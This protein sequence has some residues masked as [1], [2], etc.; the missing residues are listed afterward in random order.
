MI[1]TMDRFTLDENKL[2]QK[3][4]SEKLSQRG[5][6]DTV[7][8]KQ[9][10]VFQDLIDLRLLVP[11]HG[12]EHWSDRYEVL[13]GGRIAWIPKNRKHENLIDGGND[14]DGRPFYVCRANFKE[15]TIPGKFYKPTGCCYV[16]TGG[17]E[18]CAQDYS[19]MQKLLGGNEIID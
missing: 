12:S 19:L 14:G 15:M 16:A 18:H 17:K 3:L 11:K 4:S 10:I 1:T 6:A 8:I 9:F 5:K 13:C 2:T 7:G